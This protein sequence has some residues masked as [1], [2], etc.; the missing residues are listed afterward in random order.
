MVGG[1]ELTVEIVVVG[2]EISHQYRFYVIVENR[3]VSKSKIESV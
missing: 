2:P 3:T 1:V